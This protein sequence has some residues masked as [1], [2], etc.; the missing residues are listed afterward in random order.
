M[1]QAAETPESE[2]PAQRPPLPAWAGALIATA[3]A[4][5]AVAWFWGFSVDDAFIPARVAAHLL[6]G[7]GP[8]FQPGGPVTDAV[9]PLGF[10][11]WAAI[12][13]RAVGSGPSTLAVLEVNR[14]AG[15]VAWLA[16]AALLG[17]ELA[18]VPGAGR[19]ELSWAWIALG[20]SVPLAAWAGSGL[21]T[22]WV[23]LL[24][25][26]ALVTAR[27][28]SGTGHGASLPAGPRRSPWAADLCAGL[29]AAW[30]PEMLLW[31]AVLTLTRR[32]S[33]GCRGRVAAFAL[34]L[35]PAALVAAVR[36]TYFGRPTPLSLLAKEPDLAHGVRYALG[37]LALSGPWWLLAARGSFRR[38]R[39]GTWQP[40]LLPALGAQVLAVLLAGGDWMPFY[41]LV[42]PVL[43][44]V[45]LAGTLVAARDRTRASKRRVAWGTHLRGS[46]TLAA[47]MLLAFGHGDAAR[48]VMERRLAVIDQARPLLAERQ[49]IAAVDVGWLGAAAPA[50]T[51]L[52]LAGVTDPRV[53]ALPGGHTTKR[54]SAGMLSERDVDALVFLAL[55]GQPAEEWA[56]APFRYGVEGRLAPAAAAMGFRLVGRVPLPGTEWEYLVSVLDEP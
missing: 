34:C 50:A 16:A 36:W 47:G 41:R 22:P 17:R 35:G 19:R 51:L 30:R 15:A 43:P 8:S 21:E 24:A 20:S 52:D 1:E 4:L 18:R 26:G 23:T 6:A 44:G 49:V 46:I 55:A 2:E 42:V 27:G 56:L 53:A 32:W 12:L 10:A 37:A 11:H 9:T 29:A 33:A 39:A 7:Q 48:R 28:R 3:W 25:T 31:A 38:G 14:A 45:I 13:A 40:G 5:P 54:I